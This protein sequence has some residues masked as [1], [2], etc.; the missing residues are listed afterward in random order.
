MDN[1]DTNG[2]QITH[3]EP[4][5]RVSYS[6]VEKNIIAYKAIGPFNLELLQTL[7][8][9]ESDD[10]KEVI[11]RGE[12]IAIIVE[13]EKSCSATNEFFKQFTSYLQSLKNLGLENL[14]SA[15]VFPDETEGAHIMT[16]RYKHC[17]QAA[18]FSLATFKEY[19]KA[20]LWVKTKL[21]EISG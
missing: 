12:C 1:K 6:L 4:H 17:Y 2:A 9:I 11:Q 8:N 20:L 3:F 14:I 10:I 21:T 16:Q 19:D 18:G 15:Y 7:R 5:G 13:F